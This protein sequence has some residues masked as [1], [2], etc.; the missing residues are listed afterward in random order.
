[1]RKKVKYLVVGGGIS[2]LSF[3]RR[4][5]GEDYLIVEKDSTLGGL[6]R[7]HYS[8]EYVWDYAGHFF[9]FSNPELKA[10]FDSKVSRE[11]MVSCVKNTKIYYNGRYIDFPF[12]KNIHQ[13]PQNEFID[14]LYDLFFKESKDC[15]EDFED[16]LY[17]KFGKSIT[18]KFLKPYNEKLYACSLK[19]LDVNAMGRF[20]PYADVRDII[21]NMK[22]SDAAS[23]NSTFEYP[24]RGAQVFIEALL[25]D[26]DLS[27]VI[28]SSEVVKIEF[29]NKVAHIESEGGL[30][31]V[32]YQYIINTIPLNFFVQ[33][34]GI[35]SNKVLS[36]NQVLVFNI[37]FDDALEVTDAHW[38]YYPSKDF[39]FYRVG[40]YNNILSQKNGSIYVEIGFDENAH[41][42]PETIKTYYDATIND[43][44]KC[45]V[46]K[47]QKVVD[48][49]SLV[50]NPGYV[51]ITDSSKQW[52]G[53]FMEKMENNYGIYSIGRYGAWTYCSMEDSMIQANKL[54]EELIEL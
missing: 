2:A 8:G 9:H 18:E 10:F 43:L 51:H 6:C 17:G 35:E 21:K 39:C 14:C 22:V 28:L 50:I 7:T 20:F 54:A 46:V 24:K 32:E 5:Q 23:Y 4:A 3:A 15:Y 42:T 29:E 45:G 52:V 40:F 13:L 41:I 48:Y 27:K 1:M 19:T 49:E 34:C 11:E 26:V 30:F 16:M 31:E 47:N 25:N 37:G 36:Y 38:L 44:H 53:D 12:Q 33:L